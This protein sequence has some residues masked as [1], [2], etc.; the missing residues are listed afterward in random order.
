MLLYYYTCY[1]RT[2]EYMYVIVLSLIHAAFSIL[3]THVSACPM[4]TSI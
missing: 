1:G 2:V 4:D 3:P